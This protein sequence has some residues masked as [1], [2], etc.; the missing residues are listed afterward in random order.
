MADAA[1]LRRQDETGA[2]LHELVAAVDAAESVVLATVVGT[3]HSV[4]RHAGS[5]MLVR[6]GGRHSGSLGGGVVEE[7]VVADALTALAAGQPRLA[8]YDLDGGELGPCGGEMTVYLEPYLPAPAVLVVGCG[9]VGQAVVELAH[10]LGMRVTATDVRPQMVGED[11]LP[12]ADV[13][14]PGA[15]A[16]VLGAAAV[17]ARTHVVVTTSSVEADVAALPALLATPAASIQVMGS[18]RRWRATRAQ[19]LA[20]GVPDAAL[21]RVK[22]PAGLDVGAETPREIALAILGEIVALGGAGAGAAFPRSPPAR[23][24]QREPARRA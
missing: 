3:C 2:L 24:G 7:R 20:G 8:R 4:P 21:A 1:A 22:A 17:T 5:K 6:P 10:W 19:L 18:S 12:G 15:L 9:H 23:D 13:R 11:L 14:L 16:E